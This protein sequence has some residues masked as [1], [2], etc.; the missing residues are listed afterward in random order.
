MAKGISTYLSLL[1]KNSVI[2]KLSDKE[3]KLLIA[4]VGYQNHFICG[5][6]NFSLLK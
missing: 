4:V 2:T 1:W 3:K 5:D 6:A